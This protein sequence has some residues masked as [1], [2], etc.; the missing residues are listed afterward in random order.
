MLINQVE[1]PIEKDAVDYDSSKE[2]VNRI[3]SMIMW[4][5]THCSDKTVRYD[6]GK[7]GEGTGATEGMRVR[8]KSLG[9]NY[10]SI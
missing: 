2:A 7:I 9:G 1:K 6:I 5:A 4:L 10:R 8:R 3:G